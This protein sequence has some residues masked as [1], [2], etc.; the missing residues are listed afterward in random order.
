MTA[1]VLR[2][3]NSWRFTFSHATPHTST[4]AALWEEIDAHTREL[5]TRAQ[6]EG[7]LAPYASL[8]WTGQVYYAL[9]SP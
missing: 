9:M 3:K 4:A 1:N 8:E 6:R 2:V 5:L 7:L